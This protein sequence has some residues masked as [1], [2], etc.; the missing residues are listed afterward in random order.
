LNTLLQERDN[1]GVST[2]TDPVF[3]L[4]CR[5]TGA[6]PANTYNN[7]ISGVGATITMNSNGALA[8]QDGH[9]LSVG[10]NFLVANEVSALKNGIY[11]V[12]VLGDGSTQTVLTRATYSDESS[13]LYPQVV[14]LENGVTYGGQYFLQSTAN[15]IVGSSNI[16]YSTSSAPSSISEATDAEMQDSTTTISN[17]YVSPRKFWVG[18]TYFLNLRNVLQSLTPLGTT[19]A[20]NWN[21][22]NYVNLSIASASGNVTLSFSNPSIG[23][24]KIFVTQH[25]TSAKNLILPSGVIWLDSTTGNTIY[26]INAVNYT[27]QVI[28]DGTNYRMAVNRETT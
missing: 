15:P 24:M 2:N 5:T 20:I 12:T 22:G 9:S 7:G 27:I 11:T 8:S 28:Y 19:Q 13:E 26:G 14:F 1:G 6:L 17:H 4:K 16:V 25:P 10:D 18:L 23:E 3:S 21:N